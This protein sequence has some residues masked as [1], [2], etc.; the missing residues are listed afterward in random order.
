MADW[1]PCWQEHPVRV[2]ALVAAGAALIVLLYAIGYSVRYGLGQGAYMVTAVAYGALV[3][4]VL[5]LQDRAPDGESPSLLLVLVPFAALAWPVSLAVTWFGVQI[6]GM[7]R[8]FRFATGEGCVAAA[9][10]AFAL[11]VAGAPLLI[12]SLFITYGIVQG[13][14]SLP[15]L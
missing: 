15:W 2:L 9:I 5:A 3:Y 11:W 10:V 13:L 14:A 6:Y 1:M 12:L 8:L 7:Y 4:A